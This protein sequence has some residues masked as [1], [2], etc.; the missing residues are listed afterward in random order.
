[1]E[2][3]WKL[4]LRVLR[5]GVEVA[6]RREESTGERLVE[7]GYCNEHEGTPGPDV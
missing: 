2:E 4:L 1:M 7:G 3:F 5:Y 6:G